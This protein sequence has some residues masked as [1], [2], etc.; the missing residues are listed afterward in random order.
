MTVKSIPNWDKLGFEIVR[1]NSFIK[2]VW[3][4]G[5]WDGGVL[6][7]ET[8]KLELDLYSSA[9]HYG[10]ACFE[11]LK[12]FRGVDNKIRIFRPQL[13]A[14]RLQQSCNA[15]SMPAPS[16]ELFLDALVRVVR[17]NA[18]F[19]PPAASKGSLYIRPF[20]VGSG[21]VIGLEPAKEYYFCIAVNPV[22]DY[23]K[24]GMGTPC[25]ALVQYGFDRAAPNGNGHVKLAGNYAPVLGPTNQ[26]KKKGYTIN[27]FLDAKTQTMVEE[28]A[29][30]NFAALTKPDAEGKRTYVTPLSSSILPSITNRSLTELAAL[31]F[32][33]RVSRRQ[34]EWQEGMQTGLT[35]VLRGSFDEVAACGTA[36]VITP[37]GQIDRE[38]VAAPVEKKAERTDIKTLW[39]PETLQ[40]RV[41]LETFVCKSDFGGFK[42]LYQVYRQIQYGELED[43]FGWLYPR[44]GI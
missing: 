2:Y 33:W 15:L 26:A 34:V 36:V 42:Q 5:K 25:K 24:G 39:E 37:V 10:Q 1:T 3:Q 43:K 29:T 35:V 31:H 8:T 32:G 30:S 13:N 12:A 14:Q 19:V 20:V 28:F 17:D 23:Y 40:P 16:E 18:D 38:V 41:E 4:D 21:G 44:E 11:G 7:S 27:L 9:L 6:E 22:G